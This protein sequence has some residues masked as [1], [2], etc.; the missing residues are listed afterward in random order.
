VLN[1]PEMDEMRK[2]L[3][4]VSKYNAKVLLISPQW[5]DVQNSSWKL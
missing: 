4:V 2:N 5:Q 1:S 3:L